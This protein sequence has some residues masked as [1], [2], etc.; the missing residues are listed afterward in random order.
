MF[1]AKFI[2]E[3][4]FLRRMFGHL[5]EVLEERVLP[6]HLGAS[7]PPYEFEFGDALIGFK[8]KSPAGP[9]SRARDGRC[10]AE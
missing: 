7:L 1:R 4:L 2:E 10:T 6:D 8:V 5:V 9:R 3:P